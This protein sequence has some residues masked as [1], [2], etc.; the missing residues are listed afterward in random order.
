MSKITAALKKAAEER[1]ERKE[2]LT[3]MNANNNVGNVKNSWLVWVF[4]IGVVVTVLVAFNYDKGGSAVPLSEIFPD[5]ETYS[6]EAAYEVTD[7]SG[8]S[9]EVVKAEES[10]KVEEVAEVVNKDD[11][12]QKTLAAAQKRIGTS[13]QKVATTSGNASDYQ[14]TIQVASFKTNQRA[15]TKLTEIVKKGYE[16]FVTSKDLGAKGIWHRVY[17]GKYDSK[18]QA[19]QALSNVL[20][21][22]QNSFI[23]SPKKAQ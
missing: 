23:I 14:Y 7:S 15:E 22:F 9:Q 17:I 13:D 4:F 3:N 5:E 2:E 11:L 8:A 6:V 18:T 21:D 12:A 19:Q 1:D 10:S 20:K 16:G